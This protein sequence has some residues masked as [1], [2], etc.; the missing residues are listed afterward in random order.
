MNNQDWPRAAATA[1]IEER[2]RRIESSGLA[3]NLARLLDEQAAR[4]PDAQAWFFFESSET[5]SYG[6]L[7]RQVNR[8]AAG[9]RG[10]GVMTGTHVSAM[11][12]NIAAMPL[13]WLALARLGAVLV[14]VNTRYT[15]RE[16]HYV[17]TDSH[18]RHL[19]IG[20]QYLE[21]LSAARAEFPDIELDE[22]IV[23]PDRDSD[24]G[25]G[26]GSC[27]AQPKWSA[28]F[29]GDGLE[30]PPGPEPD[31]DSLL[32]IQYTSGTT[33]F[34][35]GCMLPH[36]YWLIVG[37]SHAFCDGRSYRR[38]LISQPLFYMTGMWQFVMSL[39]QGATAY[40][41]ARQSATHF[42]EWVRKYR[43]DFCI[44]PWP[45]YR[46]PENLL[47][48]KNDIVRANIYGFPKG[49]HADL[50]RRFNVVAREGYGM[51]EIGA[52]MFTPMEAADKV[53]TGTCGIP[54]PF[55]AFRIVDGRGV[56]VERGSVGELWVRGPGMM[57]GYYGKTEATAA[58]FR[59]DWFRTGDLFWQ[60]DDG[61]YYIVGR[62]KD[63]VRRAG[64]NIAAREVET[65][66][67]GMEQIAETAVVAVPDDTRGEEVKACV[68]LRPGLSPAD[69][70]PGAILKYCEGRLA[71]FKIPRYIEY[72][73]SELPKTP[74]GKI[75]KHILLKEKTD[76]RQGCWDSAESRWR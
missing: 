57:Q 11:L 40:V 50:E 76:L 71:I 63:M 38:V 3:G 65:V 59:G 2:I 66:L 41:A 5:I 24:A 74:S 7:R 17:L 39:Y 75:A 13:L 18:S 23:V 68:V 61:F 14:P 58:A 55:R 54:M 69:V 12:P 26:A 47:D 16:L 9:L 73:E 64:E 62:N 21:I 28:L 22:V 36:R 56:E 4:I 32:N 6:D 72:R 45:V 15:A 8:L 20:A 27:A 67:L 46:Q 42:M 44:M 37:K 30:P 35:K 10:L 51:T 1:S 48:S 31:A 49:S 43:I 19:V 33:G 52:G 60:D 34:P 25:S 70:P 53:G 29:L